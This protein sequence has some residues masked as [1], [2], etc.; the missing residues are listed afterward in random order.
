MVLVAAAASDRPYVSPAHLAVTEQADNLGLD[1]AIKLQHFALMSLPALDHNTS[2][3]FYTLP[4]ENFSLCA[5]PLESISLCTLPQ[6]MF[7]LCTL[8]LEVFSLYTLPLV[9][10]LCTF[11]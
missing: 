2:P 4:L 6:E 11:P 1:A 10:S 3:N 5:L 9:I 8:P 7:S